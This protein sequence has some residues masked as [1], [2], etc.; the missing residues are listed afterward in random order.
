LRDNIFHVFYVDSVP[1]GAA[2]RIENHRP[3]TDGQIN[4]GIQRPRIAVA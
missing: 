4:A 3:D 1:P 2:Q